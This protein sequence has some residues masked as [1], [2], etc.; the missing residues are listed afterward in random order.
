MSKKKLRNKKIQRKIA[1][2]R[3]KKL[4]NMAKIRAL[5]GDFYFANHYVFLARKIAM[6]YR[7]LLGKE[8]KR[9]FCRNCYSFLVPGLNCRV[10]IQRGKIII[11]C[12]NCEKFMR[13]PLKNH[14]YLPSARLK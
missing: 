5:A 6:R 7:L 1:D 12:N 13:I 14:G 10:R 4:F 9:S 11:F 2:E 8:Y 3:I